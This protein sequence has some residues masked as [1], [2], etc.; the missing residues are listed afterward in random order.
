MHRRARSRQPRDLTRSLANHTGSH[1]TNRHARQ[2][3][4]FLG[5]LVSTTRGHWHAG[6]YS[7]NGGPSVASTSYAHPLCLRLETH[8]PSPDLTPSCPFCAQR[9]KLSASG[10]L[11]VCGAAPM[12]TAAPAATPNGRSLRETRLDRQSSRRQ[13]YSGLGMR[14]RSSLAWSA[15]RASIRSVTSRMIRSVSA[16]LIWSWRSNSRNSSTVSS[17]VID[18][19]QRGVLRRSGVSAGST[20]HSA[21]QFVHR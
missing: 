13:T 14:R 17:S 2:R 19:H 1:H 4:S 12:S 8:E 20:P 18:V 7:G 16:C 5:L 3:Y 9:D 11:D 15:T 10:T 6:Q 21:P